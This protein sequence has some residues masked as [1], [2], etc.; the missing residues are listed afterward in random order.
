VTQDTNPTGRA[1]EPSERLRDLDRRAWQGIRALFGRQFANLVLGLAG[2]IALAR[3]LSPA[4]FGVYAI[5]T[6]VV[7]ATMLLGDLGL[8]ASL[9]QRLHAPSDREL[10]LVFT[11]QL[12]LVSV[13][14]ALVW[15]ASTWV[16]GLFHQLGGDVAWFARVFAL[17]LY[18][19]IV[20]SISLIKLERDLTYRPIA[21]AEVLEVGTYQTAAVALAASGAGVWSFVV[22]AVL[23]AAAGAAFLFYAARWPPRLRWAPSETRVLIRY[24]LAFQAGGIVNTVGTWATP[25]FVGMLVG[26]RA[27]GL[28]GLASSNAKRPLLAVES[29][30]RVSF[31]HFSRLQDERVELER[32]IVRYLVGFTWIVAL[33]CALI[34]TVGPQLIHV[35]YSSKWDAAA[36]AMRLFAGSVPFD[37]ISWT[38]GFAYAAVNRNWVAIRIV[39]ARSLSMFALSGALV[40]LVGFIGIPLAYLFSSIVT[41]PLLLVFF[42]PGFFGQFLRRCAWI[43]PCIGAA[44]AAGLIA[45]RVI[46]AF[47]P[48]RPLYALLIGAGATLAAF[49]SVSLAFAP[50]SSRELLRAVLARPLRASAG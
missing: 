11:A 43:A 14:V 47:E 25:V 29:I 4:Q 35:V 12:I 36:T 7:G 44:V 48:E 26:P 32:V 49:L 27:V 18:L 9:I 15:V 8:G 41:I 37:A 2:G 1:G 46:S 3:I 20:R 13:V 34:W 39:A 22:A 6:F 33:W 28:V 17:T 42:G 31:P 45:I 23:S 16:F 30:M 5:V 21:R 40:P 38:M 19:R 24:G 50:R 10:Q